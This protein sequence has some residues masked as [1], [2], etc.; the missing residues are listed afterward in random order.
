M[1]PTQGGTAFGTFVHVTCFHFGKVWVLSKR[2]V[3][4]LWAIRRMRGIQLAE[5]PTGIE[6]HTA[7]RRAVLSAASLVAGGIMVA[8]IGAPALGSG[9]KAGDV[10]ILN[11]ALQLEELKVALYTQALLHANLT[12]ELAQYA[13][14]VGRQEREHVAF[15]RKTLGSAAQPTPAFDFG[16]AVTDANKFGPAARTLE[17]IAVAA[18]DGQAASLTKPSLAAVATIVSVEGRHAAW[19]RDLLGELPAPAPSNPSLTAAQATA[20]VHRTGFVKGSA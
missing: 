13:R 20:A 14:V 2:L 11:F 15:L 8:G 10:E 9:S 17:D 19:I 4:F 7:S 16:E 3:F 6:Q 5:E 1:T 12:G 18:F